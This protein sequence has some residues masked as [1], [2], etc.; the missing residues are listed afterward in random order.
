MAVRRSLGVLTVC[1][2]LEDVAHGHAPLTPIGRVE[3]TTLLAPV[4]S[5]NGNHLPAETAGA[6]VAMYV[7]NLEHYQGIDL[8][9]EGFRHTLDQMGEA[10]LVIVGGREDDIVRYGQRATA[11]GI[12]QAVHFLGPK[13]V[14]ALGDLLR[15][16]DVLVSPRLKGLNTPMKIYSYLDSGT[17]VLA[18]RLRTHTQVLDDRNCL[19][20]RARAGRAGHRSRDTPQGRRAARA[21]RRGGEGP[22]ATGVHARGRPPQAGI[23][24]RHD[25]DARGWRQ[26]P[27]VKRLWNSPTIR[28]AGIYAG[29]GAGFALA[30]L[31]L[32]R[33]LP[34]EEYALV[35]LVVALVNVGFALAP[36]GID[37]MVN[38]RHLEAGPRLLRSSLLATTATGSI[39]ALLGIAFYH[40]PPTFTAM[41]FVS[42]VVGGALMVAAAKFQSE[43][44]F[45]LSLALVQSPNLVL[46][47]AALATVAVGVREAWL[48]LLIMTVGWFP[49]AILGWRILFRER[50]QKGHHTAEFPWGEA[51]SF[52]GLQATGLLL[53]Q[54]ERL[55]LPH[56]LPLTDLATFGVLAAIVGSLF[57][58]LQMG[59]GYTM[60]PRLRH[61]ADVRQRRRIVFKEGPAG[62]RRRGG[63]VGRDLDRHPGRR[64]L[65]SRRQVPPARRPDPG[66]GGER[67]FQGHQRLH[68]V[69]RLRPGNARRA[70]LRQPGWDGSR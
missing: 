14:S 1:A 16:A 61:A 64:K 22:R 21:A 4:W 11:L 69:R 12:D 5:S 65:V 23:I 6:P 28:T 32:A 8:L 57:R 46:L 10:R 3:D 13:P 24:L 63:R 35:T 67:R 59:V 29:A 55:I 15:E 17:A 70:V 38:R 54:L 30:N 62:R 60:M 45:G 51:L 49:G 27:G 48:P 7:G 50:H 41:I 58:V 47:I 37:G 20:G 44:R 36:V 42:V 66:S 18:T 2:A 25:R 43:H 33:V 40:M 68:Q 34:T 9:L 56:L 39:F 26:G 53:V 19:P 52:A 31:I